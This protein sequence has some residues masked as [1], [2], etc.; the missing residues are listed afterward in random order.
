MSMIEIN[1]EDR[2]ALGCLHKLKQCIGEITTVPLAQRAA[3]RT[4]WGRMRQAQPGDK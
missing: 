1:L 2:E 4:P 3:A